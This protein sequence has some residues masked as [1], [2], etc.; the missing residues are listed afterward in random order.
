MQATPEA[1]E[2]SRK[3]SSFLSHYINAHSRRGHVKW[4]NHHVKRTLN[5]TL[6][7]S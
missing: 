4:G 3:L 7:V 6:L 5:L 1:T 2:T